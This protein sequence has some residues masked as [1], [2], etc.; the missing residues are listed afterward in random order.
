MH[1]RPPDSVPPDVRDTLMR[2]RRIVIADDNSDNAEM[3]AML[4]S[5]AGHDVRWVRDGTEAMRLF[6]DTRLCSDG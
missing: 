6:R 2:R 5:F 1:S 4:L 3:L